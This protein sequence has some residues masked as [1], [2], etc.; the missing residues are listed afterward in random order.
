MLHLQLSS[1]GTLRTT[2]A[3]QTEVLTLFG[4]RCR[5]TCTTLTEMGTARVPIGQMASGSNLARRLV[6]RSLS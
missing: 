3:L 5:L 2:E 6:P 1:D 4:Q